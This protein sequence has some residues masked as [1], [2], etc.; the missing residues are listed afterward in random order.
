MTKLVE[1]KKASEFI[2][3]NQ[4]NESRGVAFRDGNNKSTILMVPIINDHSP[5]SALVDSFF[6]LL[7]APGFGSRA[8]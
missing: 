5:Y 8:P 4:P 7:V 2:F 6:K 1:G 3:A